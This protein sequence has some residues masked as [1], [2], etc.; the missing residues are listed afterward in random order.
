MMEKEQIVGTR[1]PQSLINDPGEI[2]K[3]DQ[4]DRS[5]TLRKLLSVAVREW[6]LDY[7]TKEYAHGRITMA[8]A[9]E[10]AGVP[11]WEM[12]DCARQQKVPAQYS[13]ED[14]NHDMQIDLPVKK[15]ARKSTRAVRL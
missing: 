11:L 5:T 10:E 9:A 13:L 12:L 3:I 4:S 8:R 2:E 14:F 6:K 15:T 1:L 7:Y